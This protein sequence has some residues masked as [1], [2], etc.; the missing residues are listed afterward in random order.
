MQA[1]RL[2]KKLAKQVLEG[3]SGAPEFEQS[4]RRYH[5]YQAEQ[6]TAGKKTREGKHST[7]LAPLI[8]TLPKDQRAANRRPIST[9]S[10]PLSPQ[11]ITKTLKP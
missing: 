5:A 6:R 11:P 3:T 10:N 1:K 4:L 2:A 9:V 7:K 8:A